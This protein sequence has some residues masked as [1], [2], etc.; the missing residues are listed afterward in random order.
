MTHQ[1]DQ[2]DEDNLY[3]ALKALIKSRNRIETDE[4]ALGKFDHI[5]DAI[6]D[7]IEDVNTQKRAA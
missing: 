1:Y 4:V 2:Q 5:T 7:L 6:S 3:A